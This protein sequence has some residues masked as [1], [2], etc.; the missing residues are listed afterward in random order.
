ME[1]NKPLTDTG[2]QE[3]EKVQY[4]N[5]YFTPPAI[6]NRDGRVNGT[7]RSVF[8]IFGKRH[9]KSCIA[10]WHRAIR[11]LDDRQSGRNQRVEPTKRRSLVRMIYNLTRWT[12]PAVRLLDIVSDS[13]CT[14]HA[15]IEQAS[16][17]ASLPT[18]GLLGPYQFRL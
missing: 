10:L 13:D 14:G 18:G 5:K 7:T 16:R 9:V 4:A 15:V 8:G 11:Y 1:S 17:P 2:R 6:R 12:H 3:K